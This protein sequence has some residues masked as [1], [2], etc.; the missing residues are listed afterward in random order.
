LI[1][2]GAEIIGRPAGVVRPPLVMPTPGE[3]ATLRE[4]IEKNQLLDQ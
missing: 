2:A 4:I 3:Y 1:K